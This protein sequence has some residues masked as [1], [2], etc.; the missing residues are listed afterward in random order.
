[1]PILGVRTTKQIKRIGCA[2]L[3]T[4]VEN[5]KLLVFDK[6]VI[7]EFSTFIEHNGSFEA[8]EGYNDDLTMTLVLFA[9]ATNDP[10]FKDLM[11][12]NNR[13]ALFR[14]QMINIEEELTPF[15]YINDGTPEELLPEVVDGDLW[16]TE[17]YQDN[18]HTGFYK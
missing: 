14:Q 6:D 5:N 4:L 8:D 16:L 15:G 12:A 11:N 9:W 18:L 10:L 7:S 1:M 3:K 2:S 17:K 13:E